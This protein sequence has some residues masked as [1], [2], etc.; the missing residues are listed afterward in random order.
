VATFHESLTEL[1]R[2]TAPEKNGPRH[3][4]LHAG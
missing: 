1:D 2:V 3:N 4:P